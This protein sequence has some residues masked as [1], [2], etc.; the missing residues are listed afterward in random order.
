MAAARF[1]NALS[2]GVAI[3]SPLISLSAS[4]TASACLVVDQQSL[5][6][7]IFASRCTPGNMLDT[8]AP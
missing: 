3:C 6:L 7:I 5:G 4:V 2:F 1:A 8:S